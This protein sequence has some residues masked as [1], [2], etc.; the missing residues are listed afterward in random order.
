VVIV[1]N[2]EAEQK[3]TKLCDVI[4]GGRG[5]ELRCGGDDDADSVVWKVGRQWL[6][7]GTRG[8]VALNVGVCSSEPKPRSKSK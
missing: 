2:P 4:R 7:R 5:A 8:A 1:V 6:R 3:A